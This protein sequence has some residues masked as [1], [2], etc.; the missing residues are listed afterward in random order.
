VYDRVHIS[1]VQSL[2]DRIRVADIRLDESE[3][4]NGE[5]LNSLLFDG[6]RIER[7]EVIDCRD[8]MTII[9]ESA[10]EMPTD[11]TGT[12]SNADVHEI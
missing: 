5:V 6:S 8:V 11:K 4:V 2:K 9:Q 12:T 10:T 7:V 3:H 1:G